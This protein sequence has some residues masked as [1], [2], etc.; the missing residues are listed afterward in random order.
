MS[1]E[2][3]Q[4]KHEADLEAALKALA[5]KGEE[6]DWALVRAL[7]HRA[8]HIAAERKAAEFCGVI[9]PGIHDTAKPMTMPG[10]LTTSGMMR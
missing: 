8:V 1:V 2:D 5:G 10:R 4:K 3:L 9:P 7:V 6:S